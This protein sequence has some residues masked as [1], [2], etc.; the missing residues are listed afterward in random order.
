MAWD[1]KKLVNLAGEI[2]N[3]FP[4]MKVAGLFTHEGQTYNASDKDHM[5]QV[6]TQAQTEMIEAGKRMKERWGIAC[7]ISVGCTLS[8]WN[9]ILPGITEIR[10][11]TYIFNDIVH[12]SF[13]GNINDCA[14]TI[15]AAITSKK[16]DERVVADAGAK[17]MTIDQR[18]SG[19]VKTEGFGKIKNNP[20]LF[21]QK[22]SDE[23][24]V[25]TSG[26]SLNIGDLIQ[27][28][29]N[30]VCPTVNLYNKAYGVRKGIVEK[31]F[32]I[33]ARGCNQ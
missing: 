32:A 3:R 25:I 6:S 21:I 7:E 33:T 16:G 30:H 22:L 23:H 4:Y 29:P 26:S 15:L 17:S 8:Q 2:V 1:Q 18:I 19:V 20:K 14:A 24:A 27:I 28:I 31:I 13:L 5:K 10:P 12:T 11:G 9:G